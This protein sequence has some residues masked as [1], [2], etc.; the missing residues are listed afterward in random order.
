MKRYII[1]LGLTGLLLAGMFSCKK[2]ISQTFK[3]DGTAPDV[4]LSPQTLELSESTASDTVETISWTRADFG[5]SAAVSY[6]VE[7]DL[8][9]GGFAA[10][11]SVNTG[12][13]PQLKY[14]GSV[15]NELAIGL[16]IAAGETGDLDIRIKSLLSDSVFIYSEVSQL[17]VTPYQV[18]FPA[19]LVLGGNSWQTPAVRTNGFVLTSPNYDDKYEGYINLPNADG[20]GGDALKLMV[21]SSGVTYGWGG[22]AN[23]MTAGASGNLWFTPAPN[24]MKVNADTKA[25]TVNFVPVTFTVTGD[26]N[27]W[28]TE[29]TPMTYDPVT[30]RLI[31]TGVNFTAGNAFVFT[32]NGGYDLS[33]KVN[34]DGKLI[35]AGP[36][37]WSGN[38]IP[39]PGTGTY[40]VILDLSAGDGSYTYSFE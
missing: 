9:G 19:L 8:A 29:A 40:T 24:F 34:G 35:Y 25:G 36:P 6:T 38:N 1:Q 23:T 30:H 14:L 3:T 11:K 39:A 27:G 20:W 28:D 13:V 12:T 37:N 5:Y 16:G 26:H 18:A 7:I 22:T 32:A 31:A 33:Y 4:T 2:D 10:P 21:E 15:L 17:T